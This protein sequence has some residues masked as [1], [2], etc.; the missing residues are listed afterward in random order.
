MKNQDYID[1]EDRY[2]AHNYKPLD[3]VLTRGE[4]VWVYDVEG[5]RYL[6]C[7]SAYSA[8][9]QGHVHPKILAAMQDQLQKITLTSRAFRNDQMPL[10]FK[11]LSDLSGY[12]MSLLMNSGAEAVETAIKLARK[13]AYRIKGIERNHAEIIVADGNFHGRTVTIVSFSSDEL[14]REDFGP[15]T[16]GF[17]SVRYGDAAAVEAAIT[18][19]TAAVMLEPIQGEGGVIIPPVGYLKKVA[20]ICRKNNVLFIAD[21]IQTGLGR[22]GKLFACDHENV[23]PDMMIIG[24]ALAGGFYPVSAVLSSAKILGLFRPGEHGSTFGGNPLGA[25]V[26]RTALKVL[27]EEGM[28]EN[29]A[30]MGEYFS[31]QLAEMPQKNI[32]EIRSRGL[33]IGVEMKTEAGLARGYCE[34]LQNKG[35]LAKETHDTTIRFA[36]PLIIDKAVIDWAMPMIRDV[37]A[38]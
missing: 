18:P 2:G 30:V 26:A 35:I 22:T 33:L 6:D 16:P 13:W 23:K 14:Y 3:V 7:L 19:N 20:D 11:E 24:K 21:E 4:G 34:G 38:K 9:N 36:P 29:A 1:L 12:E 37:L 5:K 31:E 32:R 10:L 28:I 17:I 8:L 25:A 27:V 15:Y